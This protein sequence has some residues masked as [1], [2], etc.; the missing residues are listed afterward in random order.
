MKKR[1]VESSNQLLMHFIA[2]IIGKKTSSCSVLAYYRAKLIQKLTVWVTV[3]V[4]GIII[5]NQ[6]S[7]TDTHMNKRHRAGVNSGL[8]GVVPADLH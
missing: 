7:G 1:G 2:N 3:C 6:C 5:P 8:R 4:C